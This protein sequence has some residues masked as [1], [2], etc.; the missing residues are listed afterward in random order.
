MVIPRETRRITYSTEIR[1]LKKRLSLS[2][3]QKEVL[4][5]CLLGDAH[6][7]NNWSKTNYRLKI[8]QCKR[9]EEYV[10]WKY[11][12]FKDWVLTV[13]KLHVSTNSMRFTTVSHTDL[14]DFH[15]IFYEEKKKIVPKDMEKFLS[16]LTLAVW[17]MDDGNAVRKKDGHVYAYNLNT[18]S[19][20][21]QEHLVLI[22]VLKKNFN[23]DSSINKNNGSYRLYIGVHAKDNFLDTITNFVIPS[24]RYKLS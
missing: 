23:V 9:Q 22:D 17:F 16:P 12:I 2:A 21:F 10:D 15:H 13:P 20:S 3:F 18:Q 5:G 11:Q 19:F 14:S 7:E 24:M 4:I 1:N 6:L 8:S